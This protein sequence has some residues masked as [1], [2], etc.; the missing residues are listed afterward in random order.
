MTSLLTKEFHQQIRQEDNWFSQAGKTF[1]TEFFYTKIFPLDGHQA[2]KIIHRAGQFAWCLALN[3]TPAFA[4][5]K[6]L[7]KIVSISKYNR[8]VSI[9]CILYT[10]KSLSWARGDKFWI[11]WTSKFH[12][13]SQ[14]CHLFY[15]QSSSQS[16]SSH[17]WTHKNSILGSPSPYSLCPQCCLFFSMR[18]S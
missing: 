11:R 12:I 16:T 14:M 1:W 7:A 8:Y 4:K 2:G 15:T 10:G 3:E 9:H 5:K 6:I 18:E 13:S 17:P